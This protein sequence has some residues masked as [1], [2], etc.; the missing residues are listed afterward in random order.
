MSM[1]AWPAGDRAV[2]TKRQLADQIIKELTAHAYI[3]ETLVSPFSL[4]RLSPARPVR[5]PPPA[6]NQSACG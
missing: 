3:E 1:T 2:K 6:R 5:R 4:R